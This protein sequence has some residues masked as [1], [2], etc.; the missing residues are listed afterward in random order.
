MATHSTQLPFAASGFAVR[1]L[2]GWVLVSAAGFIF[3][4]EAVSPFLPYFSFVIHEVQ[5]D[6]L[7]TLDITGHGGQIE[8]RMSALAIR[9]IPLNSDRHI[10]ALSRIDYTTTNLTHVLVPAVL[11]LSALVAWP[12][13]NFHEIFYRIVFGVGALVIVM[14]L[15]TPLFLAGRFEMWLSDTGA[16]S[17]ST[18]LVDW[19]IFTEGG[20]RWLLPIVAAVAAVSLARFLVQ[21]RDESMPV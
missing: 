15:T 13:K 19:V 3:S 20:G 9:D 10:P 2:L 21:P 5:H 18:W 6:F 7:P 16:P 1:L 14:G 17:V 4:R 8:L 11:L 12:V